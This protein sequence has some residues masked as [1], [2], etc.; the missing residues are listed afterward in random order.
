MSPWWNLEKKISA[1]HILLVHG[2]IS[3]SNKPQAINKAWYASPSSAAHYEASYPKHQCG[4]FVAD[5]TCHG[6]IDISIYADAGIVIL[7]KLFGS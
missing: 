7:L 1:I 6:L 2:L 3:D 5:T 4:T